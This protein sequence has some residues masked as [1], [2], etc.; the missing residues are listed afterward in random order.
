[1]PF[2]YELAHSSA[3]MFINNEIVF[4][5]A[6]PSQKSNLSKFSQQYWTQYQDKWGNS[7]HIPIE[8]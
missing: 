6:R 7:I 1:M 2:T 4:N 5:Q 3:S 8:Q